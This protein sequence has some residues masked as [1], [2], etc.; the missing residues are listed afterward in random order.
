[1]VGSSVPQIP[2]LKADHDMAQGF[3]H[4]VADLLGRRN[5]N[6]PGAQPVSFARKHLQALQQTE[7]VQRAF[8]YVPGLLLTLE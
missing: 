8:Y 5:P 7:S 1:M 3:R 4:E 6:F 2:G